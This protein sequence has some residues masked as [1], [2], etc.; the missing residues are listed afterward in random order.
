MIIVWIIEHPTAGLLIEWDD[1]PHFSWSK[2]RGDPAVMT[3]ETAEAA[4]RMLRRLL[5]L[6][7]YRDA[8]IRSWA[9]RGR[10]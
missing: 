3:F 1:R 10:I 6:S 7:R 4:E 8:F 5:T 2:A 9:W